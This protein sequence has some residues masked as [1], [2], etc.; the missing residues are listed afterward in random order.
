MKLSIQSGQGGPCHEVSRLKVENSCGTLCPAP[1]DQPRLRTLLTC[2]MLHLV[3]RLR[4]SWHFSQLLTSKRDHSLGVLILRVRLIL[5]TSLPPNPRKPISAWIFSSCL[6]SCFLP[7]LKKLLRPQSHHLMLYGAKEAGRLSQH[8]PA[9]PDALASAPNRFPLR[10]SF[11]YATI[12][13]MT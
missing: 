4:G 3:I 11:T 10:Q 13:G 1:G 9:A 5:V 6:T 2:Y 12:S 8:P 7:F